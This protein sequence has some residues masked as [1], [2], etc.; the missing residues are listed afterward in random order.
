MPA[1]QYT[2]PQQFGRFLVA[3]AL[4]FTLVFLLT[5]SLGLSATAAHHDWRALHMIVKG[6]TTQSFAQWLEDLHRAYLPF[7]S[8]AAP[9]CGLLSGVRATGLACGLSLRHEDP[10]QGEHRMSLA[11]L[12]ERRTANAVIAGAVL[13]HLCLVI[14]ANRF[15]VSLLVT[16]AFYSGIILYFFAGPLL[17]L[18]HR[19]TLPVAKRETLSDIRDATAAMAS[20]EK[21][22]P[23][24]FFDLEKGLFVGLD[25]D[26]GNKPLYA[27][28]S[29]FRKTHMQVVGTTGSG[30]G[31]AT[32]MMLGQCALAGECVVI[33]DPKFPGD[34]FAPRVLNKLALENN[35]PFYLINLSP[36]MPPPFDQ[37]FPQTPP[38]INLF[39]GCSKSELEEML[40]TAFDLADAG[41]NA[42]FYYRLFDRLAC[43]DVC[44]RAN[45]GR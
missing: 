33:F 2:L 19:T 5:S 20:L 37:E 32:T 18:W 36:K 25:I 13:L 9:A 4:V 11:K 1:A 44:A 29:K 21:Y 7:F 31:V 12:K 14:L 28:W 8:R 40:M 3:G 41:G 35:I 39:S 15:P 22:D 6:L 38:Q 10:A 26:A 24:A 23:P 27:P 16:T 34:E 42:D 43:Q 30:K 17:W 45:R